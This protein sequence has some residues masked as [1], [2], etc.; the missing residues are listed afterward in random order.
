M[1][2]AGHGTWDVERDYAMT[3]MGR[4]EVLRWGLAA[5]AAAPALGVLELFA[6]E[7]GRTRSEVDP[8]F[9]KQLPERRTQCFVC[10]LKCVLSPGQ[11]CF[12]RTRNNVD[13]KLLSFA[14]NNPCILTLDPIEKLPLSHFLPGTRTLSLAAGGCNLRCQYCQNWEQSQ[15]KPEELRT[16]DVDKHRAVAGAKKKECATIAYT[17]TEPV[18]FYEYMRDLSAFAK[19]KGLRNVCATALFIEPKP[20][21]Q[22]C[23]NIDAFAVALKAFDEKFYD[24]VLGSQ[25]KPVLDALVVLK[26]EKVWTEVVTLIV[27]TYNDDLDKIREQVRW[28]R[29]YLG[30]Q[31]PLHFGRFV[32]Q[33]KLRDLPQTPAETL[34]RC[35]DIGL[36]EGLKHVYIFNVSPHKGN[37]TYCPNCKSAVIERL[38]FRVLETRMN[39]G[40]CLACKTKLPGVWK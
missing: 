30:A 27:P 7:A 22:I 33:Y 39:A 37:N 20:L 38:G 10:P 19:E 35:R 31:T 40:A 24:R 21:R 17:Y 2:D 16:F 8:K 14:Y 13:G 9:Y 5:G 18:A 26:E 36:Q 6:Q 23:P 12:C 4:R 25:L 28:H 15:T 29:K 3:D 1:R 32:P 11:T 34:E